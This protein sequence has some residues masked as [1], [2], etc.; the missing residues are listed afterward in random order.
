M[1]G[2]LLKEVRPQIASPD[3]LS[4]L[5]VYISHGTADNVLNIEYAREANAYL[6]TIGIHPTYKEFEAGHFV[7]N[8]MVLSLIDWLK[9]E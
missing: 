4:K 6:K 9:S 5:K 2:R 3:K 1:S 8:E 7:S